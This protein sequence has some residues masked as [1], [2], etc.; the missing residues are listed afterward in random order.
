MLKKIFAVF[1]CMIIVFSVSAC[2]NNTDAKVLAFVSEQS[3][4]RF[5]YNV[6]R[7]QDLPES[8]EQSAKDLKSAIKKNLNLICSI[9]FDSKVEDYDGNCEI[10]IGDTDREESKEAIECLKA[11]RERYFLDFI[12]KVIDDKI[13]IY[14]PN[15]DMLNKGIEYFIDKFVQ[16]EESW[17]K[18]NSNTEIIYEVP[19]RYQNHKIA[20]KELDS[21]TVIG[22]R[23]MEYI[24]AKEIDELTK[25]ISNSQGYELKVTDDRAKNTDAEI[26]I[27]NTQREE[28]DAVNVTGK[29]WIIKVVNGKLVIKGG[30]SLSLGAAI[31]AFYELLKENTEKDMTINLEEGF[32]LK[33]S[34]AADKS[35]YNYVWGDEFNGESLNHYWW[36][37]YFNEKY[38]SE[39]PSCLG[40]TV[41]E[42][43]TE[44]VKFTGDGC[45]T[46]FCTRDGKN[47]TAGH[48]ATNDTMHFKYG[49]LEIR[50]K[51][52]EETGNASFWLNGAL[53][54]YGCMI[55]YDILENFGSTKSFAANVHKW[56]SMP[57]GTYHT[58]LDH[59]ADYRK[60][61]NYLFTD[62]YDPNM[63]LSTDFHVYT[64]IWDEHQVSVAVDGK[65]FFTLDLD[66]ENEGYQSTKLADYFILSCTMG[67]A[68]YGKPVEAD[69]LTYAELK[70]DYVR[71]YQHGDNESELQLRDKNLVKLDGR[72]LWREYH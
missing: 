53:L 32:E 12:I 65:I 44:N 64:L 66:E 13:C 31:K 2:G 1:L 70:V 46:I 54:G 61:K 69:G 56:S 19:I 4:K 47:F 42:K 33:G 51:L 67:S 27:G 25:F 72:E 68:D 5:A 22:V 49:I 40:G 8:N 29:D 39:S 15:E 14:S 62:E 63:D 11:N 58:S 6:V 37:D 16:S 52:P 7:S 38:G 55:E 43:G 34:F 3:D 57:S 41:T 28:S 71:L 45:A 59:D 35:D 17:K 9:S 24:Y 50:A 48:M 18:L 30:D 10:L 60:L 23:D 21:F 26:L 36:L 20:G